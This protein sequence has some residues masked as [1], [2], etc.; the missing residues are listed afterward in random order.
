MGMISRPRGGLNA[1]GPAP[2]ASYF[3]RRPAAFFAGILRAAPGLGA[4]GA[5]ASLGT[6]AKSRAASKTRSPP[7]ARAPSRSRSGCSPPDGATGKRQLTG[8]GQYDAGRGIH[9]GARPPLQCSRRSRVALSANPRQF[10]LQRRMVRSRVARRLCRPRIYRRTSSGIARPQTRDR[11]V[12]ALEVLE[13]WGRGGGRI[14]SVDLDAATGILGNVPGEIF[15]ALA[16]RAL[17]K[18]AAGQPERCP[19]RWTCP[20]SGTCACDT[21]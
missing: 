12:C 15:I 21:C 1:P 11:L 8:R 13:R 9:G 18:P 20:A 17:P 19:P 14:L 6:G 10:T 3:L 16:M 5:T 4:A 7:A 2:L